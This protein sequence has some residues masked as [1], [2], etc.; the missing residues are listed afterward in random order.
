MASKVVCMTLGAGAAC[1]AV[2]CSITMTVRADNPRTI[3][4][5]MAAGAGV[6]MDNADSIATMAIGAE[7][8][9]G[10]RCRMVVGVRSKVTGVAT[11]TSAALDSGDIVAA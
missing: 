10:Q 8:G 1:A 3:G 9:A 2:D 6:F 5:C 7:S 11:G 4:T